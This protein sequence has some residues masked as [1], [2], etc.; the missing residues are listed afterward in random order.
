MSN[1]K[2]PVSVLVAVRNEQK[3]IRKCLSS[4]Q[5][6][7]EIIIIDSTSSDDTVRIATEEYGATVV[8]FHYSGGYPKKR[9]WALDNLEF[10]SD[11]I[12]LIDADEEVPNALWNEIEQTISSDEICAAYLVRKGFHFL[13]RR[14]RFGGFS[15]SAVVLLKKGKGRFEELIE[16]NIDGL[17]MEVHE[18][19]VV[20]GPIGA[21]KTALIHEDFKGLEAYIDRHNRYSTWE[22]RLR[23]GY[24]Q[25]RVYGHNTIEPRLLGNAQERRR[26]LKQ[27]VIRMPFEPWIWFA[28]HYFFRLGFLEGRPG[29]IA[30][31]IRAAYIAQVRSKL[32]E[33]E[34]AERRQCRVPGAGE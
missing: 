21:M 20:N 1:I 27:M 6:A 28:Y 23:Y 7:R 8:Q 14:L 3:N 33:L 24:L 15:H 13:G 32:Y 18:R 17:D 11:W 19:V 31:Q 4:L 26:Y 10:S 16:D 22:A 34:L 30:S 12:L 9:Q 25:N 2:L 29:W 5:P